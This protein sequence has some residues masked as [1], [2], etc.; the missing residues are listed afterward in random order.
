MGFFF[1]GEAGHVLRIPVAHGVPSVAV[2]RGPT[3]VTQ[4]RVSAPA[5]AYVARYVGFSLLT[6]CPP[7]PSPVQRYLWR[8][9]PQK[10]DE[11]PGNASAADRLLAF[12]GRRV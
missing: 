3:P 11:R 2:Y 1:L 7:A 10:C 5:R 8:R 4:W 12:A 6:V 9:D